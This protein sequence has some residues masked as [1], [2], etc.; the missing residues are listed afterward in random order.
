MIWAFS[1]VSPALGRF[2]QI[3]TNPKK[4]SRRLNVRVEVKKKAVSNEQC[5]PVGRYLQTTMGY[6]SGRVSS[7]RNVCTVVITH[8]QPALRDLQLKPLLL[9]LLLL[10]PRAPSLPPSLRAGIGR[11]SSL[12]KWQVVHL[13]QFRAMS[14][15]FAHACHAYLGWLP[16]LT[17]SYIRGRQP[18]NLRLIF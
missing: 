17:V 16:R 4:F 1:H 9:L 6:Q 8:S 2:C 10:P 14:A 7:W 18:N 13:C 3:S 5:D 15:T 11:K 12:T